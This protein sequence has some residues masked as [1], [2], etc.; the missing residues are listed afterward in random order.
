VKA[1]P[2]A[3]KQPT[4]V[5][6]VAKQAEK[7]AAVKA[8]PAAKKQPAKVAAVAKQAEKP[9]AVKAAPAAKKV[10][11]VVKQAAK[12]AAAVKAAPAA[13]QPAK[14][15][16]AAPKPAVVA[17]S[18]PRGEVDAN[19]AKTAYDRAKKRLAAIAANDVLKP[20]VPLDAAVVAAR[21]LVQIATKPAVRTRLAAIPA[22]L[23]DPAI[24]QRLD[25]GALALF[26]AHGKAAAA[27]A[28][29]SRAKL[30][31]DLVTQATD[32]RARM[33][34]LVSYHFDDDPTLGPAVAH[35]RVGTGYADL[36]HDLSDLADLYDLR[37]DVVQGDAKYVRDDEA[38]A[39]TLSKDILDAL[40]LNIETGWPNAEARAFTALRSDYND[41]AATVSWVV[42]NDAESVTV[43]TLAQ[44]AVPD[45]ASK[46]RATIKKK[47]ATDSPSGA[48]AGT[49]ST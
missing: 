30:P 22:E 38:T 14:E 37:S 7:P 32:V 28:A 3:K 16:A 17:Q 31:A 4:K 20:Y 41:L 5:A 10:P 15:K 46:V 35:I 24:V 47:T 21:S 11:A 8:A 42:R 43:L 18:A 23:F 45:R 9:A 40:R 12:P 25:E 19:A 33:L 2:P 48:K 13:K 34:R 29:S 27:R 49:A 36:A 1:G 44:A 39:R 6:A 26:H